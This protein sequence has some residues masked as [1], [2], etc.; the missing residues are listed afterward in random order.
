[1]ALIWR[2]HVLNFIRHYFFFYYICNLPII[3]LK[4]ILEP[5]L[6]FL[7][8]LNF[9]YT[10]F[11]FMM[12]YQISKVSFED[13]VFVRLKVENS[14]SLA[15]APKKTPHFSSKSPIFDVNSLVKS[16]FDSK[17]GSFIEKLKRLKTKP[18][19]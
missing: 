13:A 19:K 18:S 12:N 10:L 8:F 1:L 11:A 14:I 7:S 2:F 6:P 9:L 3:I 17:Q 15:E 5:S 16:M 4:L